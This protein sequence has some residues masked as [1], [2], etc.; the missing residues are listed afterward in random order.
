MTVTPTSYTRGA[1]HDARYL[2]EQI[3]TNGSLGIRMWFINRDCARDIQRRLLGYGFNVELID[4]Q[5]SA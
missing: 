1:P 2:V 5:A 4:L 3:T